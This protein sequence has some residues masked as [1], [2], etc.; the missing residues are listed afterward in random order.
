MDVKGLRVVSH[1]PEVLVGGVFGGGGLGGGTFP[2]EFLFLTPVKLSSNLFQ[3]SAFRGSSF[4][5][6]FPRP[7]VLIVILPV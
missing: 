2:V 5:S 1:S 6:L 3:A 7:S 4:T